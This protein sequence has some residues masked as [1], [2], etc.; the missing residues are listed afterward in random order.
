[1]WWRIIG[2]LSLIPIA[3]SACIMMVLYVDKS[4]EEFHKRFAPRPSGDERAKPGAAEAGHT[5]RHPA[6]PAAAGQSVAA[7][8]AGVEAEATAEG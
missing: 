1:M 2:S 8:S 5:R 6:Q 7:K 3:I 4:I